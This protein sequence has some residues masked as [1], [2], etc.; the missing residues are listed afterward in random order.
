MSEQMLQDAVIDLAHA[1]NWR[2]AHFRPALTAKGWRTPVSADGA[3]WPDLILCKGKRII[4]AEL[5]SARGKFTV[6]QVDWFQAL[7]EAGVAT[8]E[9]RPADWHSGEILRVLS[10]RPAA[11]PGM[12]A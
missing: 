10:G 2:V 4:A 11:F 3:G 6:A 8:I 12:E 9:W 7:A 1:F 5:K